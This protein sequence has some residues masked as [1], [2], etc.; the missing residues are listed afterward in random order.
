V[1]AWAAGEA[2]GP[3]DAGGVL[4]TG[5]AGGADDAGGVLVDSEADGE[6][7]VDNVT[8]PDEVGIAAVG[9]ADGELLDDKRHETG[10]G[11]STSVISRFVVPGL[12][13]QL[14]S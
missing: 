8:S 3:D 9:E 2:D 5:E 14:K 13:F 12:N 11:N 4:A 10:I 1:L 6:L 7:A